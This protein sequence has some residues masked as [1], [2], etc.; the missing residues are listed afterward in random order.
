ML[1]SSLIYAVLGPINALIDWYRIEKEGKWI[2]HI[3]ETYI[4]SIMV[5]LGS[6]IAS[7]I[8]DP[9]DILFGLITIP[10][11]YWILHDLTLN[12]LRKLPIDYLGTEKERSAK[13]DLLL[14]YLKDEHGISQWNIKIILLLLLIFS[15]LMLY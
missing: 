15:G 1:I 4:L 6:F 7:F 2:D 13:T 10:G 11:S 5:L 3:S 12:K 9:K 8:F 14:G